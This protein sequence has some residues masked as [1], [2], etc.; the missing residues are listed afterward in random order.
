MRFPFPSKHN[1]NPQEHLSG[2]ALQKKYEVSRKRDIVVNQ[3]YP[4][5]LEATNTVDEAK[6]LISSMT[7]LLM[8]EV[9]KTMMERKFSEISKSLLK[10]LCPDGERE[11]EIKKLL[12]TLEGDN[13]FVAREIIEGMTRAIEQMILDEMRERK[14]DTLKADWD[15]FLN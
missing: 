13:L 7:S 2:D 9:L 6:M 3:F 12:A 10:K 4:A 14:L 5:L 1:K 11:A 15:R 8:E